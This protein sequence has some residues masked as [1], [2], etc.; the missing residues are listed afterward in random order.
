[1]AEAIRCPVCLNAG[2]GSCGRVPTRRDSFGFDCQICEITKSAD[3]HLMLGSRLTQ[4]ECLLF[5]EQR[6][7]IICVQLHGERGRP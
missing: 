3:R 7:R 4:R 5:K 1:M 6:C 2:G